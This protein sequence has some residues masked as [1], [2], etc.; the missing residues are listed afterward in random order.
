MGC[1]ESKDHHDDGF[2]I[3][4]D[5][6][7]AKL[8]QIRQQL[9]SSVPNLK[10][11]KNLAK[12]KNCNISPGKF[13]LIHSFTM[14]NNNEGMVSTVNG[15]VE[16]DWNKFFNIGSHGSFV[17]GQGN[18]HQISVLCRFLA[19]LASFCIHFDH[20]FEQTFFLKNRLTHF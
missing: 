12:V 16:F 9:R 7:R 4:T 2:G 8:R 17:E 5:K 1:A 3:P 19:F 14:K 11:L 15:M 10:S 18:F 20:I 6:N 13:G